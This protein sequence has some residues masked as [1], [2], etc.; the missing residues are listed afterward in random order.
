MK[1]SMGLSSL[2]LA[3]HN[4]AMKEKSTDIRGF[5]RAIDRGNMFEH[6]ILLVN[7]YKLRN[8][9]GWNF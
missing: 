5:E 7:K 4:P 6:S 3:K 9:K 2:N 1:S 8:Q